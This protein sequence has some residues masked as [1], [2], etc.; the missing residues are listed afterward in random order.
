[1][2]DRKLQVI[3][4]GGL[5]EFGMNCMAIRYGDDIIVVDAGMMFPD[6]E[7]LGVDI[8]TPDFTYLE[9]NREHVRGLVLTHGHE[10]HIGGIPFLLAQINRPGLR[11]RLH[12]GP[13]RA[14]AGRARPARQGPTST[15]S[16][17]AR[18][19]ELGPFSIEFIHV[20]HSIVSCVAAGHH[21]AARRHHPH[22]RFQGRPH[23]HRQR[24][25]RSAHPGRI[26][27]ARRAA[28]AVRFH[29]RRPPRLH[30]ERAR[31]PPAP[32][33]HLQPRRAPPRRLLLQLLHPPPPADPRPRRRVR[34][35]GGLPRPQHDQRHRNRPSLRPAAH[36]RRHPA[37]P[38]GHH[39]GAP[40]QGGGRS[41]AAP[42][43]SRCPRCRAWPST[44]TSISR[45]SA[46]TPW[47]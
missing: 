46:A 30:R 18:Q 22:R 32:G 25:L 2:S 42:R 8:V 47:C 33:G 40:G 45:S 34:P 37:A 9:E 23:A 6:A 26:R 7:L 29:Q 5:G 38:A 1:M 36:S 44:I 20:T 24:A 10:D 17:P 4:L 28:A 21:H 12:A 15:P 13:G 41:S 14:P 35:Q 31:R 27:Q 3:P 11:H 39:A 19:I 16:S 43:A